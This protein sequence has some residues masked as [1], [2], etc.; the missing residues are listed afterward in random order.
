MSLLMVL[1]RAEAVT[2]I[3]DTLA[4]T[5]AGEPYLLVSKCAIEP[6]LEMVIAY[7]GLAN[8]GARWVPAMRESILCRDIDNLDSHAPEM[9]RSILTDLRR[10]HGEFESSG[11][12]YHFGWSPERDQYVG[13]A[14]RSDDDFR[15]ESLDPGFRIKPHP[16][17][18]FE[19]PESLE[20]MIELA[21][22]VKAEQDAARAE[23][24]I[25]VGGELVL[26]SMHGRIV[27]TQKVH[28]FSSYETDWLAMNA[29]LEREA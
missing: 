15:S 19:T 26:T 18:G 9:L 4:T 17:G 11:T 8:L 16:A 21:E 23:D 28:R 5:P 2:V 12:I 10:Q 27:A 25:F 29:S 13:Y 20:G 3:T 14:Y 24:R 22:R 6:Q 1:L 7:T